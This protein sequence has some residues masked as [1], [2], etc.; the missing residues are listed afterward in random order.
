[1]D[2]DEMSSCGFYMRFIRESDVFFL[3]SD[4]EFFLDT[5]DDLMF[6]EPAEYFFSFSFEGEGELL[7]IECFLYF[8]G[9]FESHTREV[10]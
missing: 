8:E 6:P 2:I 9:F 5:L 4:C 10:L 7:G 3:E 1:M